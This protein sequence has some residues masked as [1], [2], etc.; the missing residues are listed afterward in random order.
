[1]QGTAGQGTGK[2]PQVVIAYLDGRR[3]RGCVFDFSPMRD[4]CRVFPSQTAQ[5]GEGEVVD[6]KKLKAIFFLLDAAP[7]S[8]STS[9]KSTG[10][11]QRRRLQVSF[12]DGERLEGTTEGYSKERQGF[13]MVPE[14]PSGKILRVYVVNANVKEVKWLQAPQTPALQ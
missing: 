6:L 1:V 2:A 14:D 8:T 4:T 3:V 11:M 10:A 5:A 13:F 9:T 12:S 7:D